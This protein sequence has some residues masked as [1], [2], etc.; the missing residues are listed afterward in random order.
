MADHKD[1]IDELCKRLNRPA[2]DI[3]FLI[4]EFAYLVSESVKSDTAVSVPS[5]GNFEPRKRLERVVVHPSTGKRL[6]IP[7][8]LTLNFR[9][10]A[11]LKQ[12]IR[13]NENNL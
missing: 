13:N 8:R 3:E 12:K 9:P 11:L 6:L 2:E 5:F 4:D 10:S 1:I 7:P